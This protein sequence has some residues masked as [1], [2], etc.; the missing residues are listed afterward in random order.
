[1]RSAKILE[2]GYHLKK[3][4][5][6]WRSETS[7]P[8]AKRERHLQQTKLTLKRLRNAGQRLFKESAIRYSIIVRTQLI[9]FIAHFV[10]LLRA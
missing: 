7:S 4:Q 6:Q 10:V 3:V 1:M 8:Q 2:I 5:K 9:S